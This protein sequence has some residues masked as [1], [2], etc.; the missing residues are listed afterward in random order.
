MT[1]PNVLIS[2]PN[3]RGW[4]HKHVVFALLRLQSDN[5]VDKNIILPTHKPYVHNLHL[6]MRDFLKGDYTHWLS[7]D[8]DNPPRNNPLDLVFM[9]LDVVGLPTPVWANM[10]EGDYPIYWNALD[11]VEDGFKPHKECKGLQKV[12][13]IGSGCML[14]S[15]RV[16]EALKDQKPFMREWNEEGIVEVGCDYSFCK[17]VRAAGFHVWAHYDYPCYHFNEIEIGE[18]AGAFAD[19]K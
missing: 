15:R 13:A 14:I 3:G 9:D 6:V 12:D 18:I 10:K 1:K 7:M 4:V 8:D 2:V 5:R 17:K 11:E 16:I 19:L